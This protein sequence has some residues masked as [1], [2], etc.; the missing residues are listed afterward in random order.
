MILQSR[1]SRFKFGSRVVVRV[2]VTR[3]S[4]P[5]GAMGVV[6]NVDHDGFVHVRWDDPT[7]PR[8]MHGYL[9][10]ELQVVG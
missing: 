3:F 4:P 6:T 5:V 1:K 7:I 2:Q 9:P 10:A 8:S